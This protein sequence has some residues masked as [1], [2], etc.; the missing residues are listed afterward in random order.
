MFIK[1]TKKEVPQKKKRKK[2]ESFFY[3]KINKGMITEVEIE[4]ITKELK[5]INDRIEVLAE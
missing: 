5:D 2:K 1:Q 4:S 3:N